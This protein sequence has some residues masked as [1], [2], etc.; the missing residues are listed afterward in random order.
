MKRH[1][2]VEG[3]LSWPFVAS[4]VFAT[5]SLMGLDLVWRIVTIQFDTLLIYAIIVD[6]LVA[7]LLTGTYSWFWRRRS[8]S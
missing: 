5:V 1:F 6:A 7:V 3:R 4:V 2:W 8:S